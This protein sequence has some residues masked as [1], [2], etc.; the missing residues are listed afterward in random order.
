MVKSGNISLPGVAVTALETAF[1]LKPGAG[2]DSV[3]QVLQSGAMTPEIAAN[4]RAADQHHAE[5]MA[6]QGIDLAE[7]NAALE[8]NERVL[9]A[10]LR[11]SIAVAEIIARAIRDGQSDGTYTAR[12]WR[13][14]AE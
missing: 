1:G 12:A 13:E 8:T 6:Q 7:L 9:G 4:V 14:R 2:A 5:V 10:Q 3:T 11:A